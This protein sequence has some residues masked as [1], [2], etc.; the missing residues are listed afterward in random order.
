MLSLPERS[1]GLF[2]GFTVPKN[3][4][5]AKADDSDKLLIISS[6]LFYRGTLWNSFRPFFRRF[7]WDLQQFGTPLEQLKI[8]PS[9][10]KSRKTTTV[11]KSTNPSFLW[12]EEA[13]IIPSGCLV[14]SIMGNN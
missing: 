13:V 5:G 14:G 3:I 10:A 4:K 12:N 11:K 1:G 2:C 9:V 8:R 6:N 7:L